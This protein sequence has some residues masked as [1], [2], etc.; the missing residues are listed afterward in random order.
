MSHVDSVV[1][2]IVVTLIIFLI[3]RVRAFI[4]FTVAC[5]VERRRSRVFLDTSMLVEGF[6]VLLVVVIFS[7]M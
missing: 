7:L 5:I 1:T 6:I 3:L 4:R 2:V